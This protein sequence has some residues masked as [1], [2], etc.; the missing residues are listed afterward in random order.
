VR[1]ERTNLNLYILDDGFGDRHPNSYG[2]YLTAC[3]FYSAIFGR[4]P[5]GST[6]YSTNNISD[7][8]YLQRIAAETV[9][10]DPFATD[11]YGFG[12]NHYY[13]VYNWQNYPNP[14]GSPANTIV[15][16]GAS[17]TPS[18]SVKVDTNV[19]VVSNLWLGTLDTNFNRSG[20]GRL[21]FFT[22][23]SLVVTGALVVGKDGKGF[24]Q[25][26]GGA[27][28]VN[29]AITLGEQTNSTGQYSLLNGALYANQILRGAGNG[30][31]NFQGGQLGFAQFGS[32]ARPLDLSAGAGTLTLTNTAGTSAIF[33]NYTNGGVAALA[34]QLGNTSNA[35]AVSGAV[36]L[37]GTLRLG[38]AAGFQPALGQQ[39][40]LLTAASVSGNFTNLVRPVVGTNGLGLT[41]SV[42]ATSVVAT[43]V[44]F[45]PSLSSA[46]LTTNGNFQFTLTSVAGSQYIFQARTNLS[47][48]NWI[49]L[50]T[51]SSPFTFQEAKTSPQRFYRAIYL[52]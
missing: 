51:N 16:S 15:I 21:Y 47:S 36:S 1:T 35:L 52:P 24:V 43:V 38:Y 12:S 42:T 32:M 31:F 20:Q 4:S 22:N 3:V 39:F 6:Y 50:Q 48:G 29:G 7:A 18:P 11:A 5:E 26:N 33:G 10:T 41:T 9:L 19:G 28:T 37:A 17:A 40:T 25:H 14:P 30:L 49:S 23:G 8:T 45:A 44:S 27:L 2:A 46:M 34:I 13:W